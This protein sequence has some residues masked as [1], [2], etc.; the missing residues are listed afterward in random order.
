MPT[1]FTSI[2]ESASFIDEVLYFF[3]TDILKILANT[4][5]CLVLCLDCGS[6]KDLGFQ[7]LPMDAILVRMHEQVE[8]RFKQ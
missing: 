5:L 6:F 4:Y 7:D 2:Q 3:R 1:G 8:K